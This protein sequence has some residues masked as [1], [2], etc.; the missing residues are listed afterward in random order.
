VDLVERLTQPGDLVLDPFLGAGTTGVAALRTG[1]RFI[2]ID[3][4]PEAV[5]ASRA[6]LAEA[7]SG[8]A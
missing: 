4:D 1:R 5:T 8:A 6:R 2:G 7:A 3:N